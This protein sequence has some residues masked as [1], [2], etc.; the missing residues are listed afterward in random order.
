MLMFNSPLFHIDFLHYDYLGLNCDINSNTNTL[1]LVWI[2]T[3]LLGP[4]VI[5]ILLTI[6]F[7]TKVI[8]SLKEFEEV[9]GIKTRRFLS[10]PFG[11]II[12]WTPT[13]I[14]KIAYIS[15]Y[16]GLW[17]EAVN[18]AFSRS[19]GLINAVIYGWHNFSDSRYEEEEEEAAQDKSLLPSHTVD[20]ASFRNVEKKNL[21]K[22]KT[23]AF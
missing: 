2:C 9:L 8:K 15:N 4:M 20:P 19:S 3:L 6:F 18:I 1:T 5:S 11:L 23:L 12:S 13:I 17:L 16:H 21:R 22:S 7:Y 14:F 10:Y